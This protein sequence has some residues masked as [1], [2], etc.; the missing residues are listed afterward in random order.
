MSIYLALLEQHQAHVIHAGDFV[1]QAGPSRPEGAC[2][3]GTGL[4]CKAR[5]G[6]VCP[7]GMSLVQLTYILKFLPARL[8]TF[9]FTFYYPGYFSM[10]CMHA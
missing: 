7:K 3:H 2:M 6:G 8:I 9:S 5:V 4:E 1:G 10:M